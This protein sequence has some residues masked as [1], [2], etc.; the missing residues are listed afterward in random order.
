MRYLLPYLLTST[1]LADVIITLQHTTSNTIKM[2]L[3]QTYE[4]MGKLNI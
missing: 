4:V 1:L 2:H 3:A